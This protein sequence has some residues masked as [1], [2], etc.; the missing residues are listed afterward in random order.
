[1]VYI[2]RRVEDEQVWRLESLHDNGMRQVR[3]ADPSELELVVIFRPLGSNNLLNHVSELKLVRHKLVEFVLL[4]HSEHK[5]LAGLLQLV[6]VL[7]SYLWEREELLLADPF[8][9]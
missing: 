6:D 5:E 4:D 3:V 2:V 7:A 8:V 9:Q 1:M